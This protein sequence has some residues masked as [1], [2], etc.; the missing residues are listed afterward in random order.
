MT[1]NRR[2]N[3]CGFSLSPKITRILSADCLPLLKHWEVPAPHLSTGPRPMREPAEGNR[4]ILTDSYIDKTTPV[5]YNIIV[6]I[7]AER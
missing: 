3:A 4:A 6:Q 5:F 2:H 1:R 7:I